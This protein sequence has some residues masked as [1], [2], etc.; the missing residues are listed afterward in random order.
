MTYG[1]FYDYN[2]TAK[3]LFFRKTRLNS[4]INSASFFGEMDANRIW[5]SG[6]GMYIKRKNEFSYYVLLFC[7][8]LF[9]FGFMFLNELDIYQIIVSYFQNSNE[10]LFNSD[11]GIFF[12]DSS[13]ITFIKY[14]SIELH[15]ALKYSSFEAGLTRALSLFQIVVPL[16]A[17]FAGLIMYHNQTSCNVLKS[18][19]VKKY[20]NF[21]RN[22]QLRIA[23]SVAGSI[24]SAYVLYYLLILFIGGGRF[25]AYTIHTD[26]FLDVLGNKFYYQHLKFYYFLLG[27][28][29]YLLI[30][31]VLAYLS[32]SIALFSTKKSTVVF[33]LLIYYFGLSVLMFP[34]VSVGTI[35]KFPIAMLFAPSTI[36][37]ISDYNTSPTILLFITNSMPLILG[38][39]LFNHKTR[40][41]HLEIS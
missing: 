29:K 30:P 25:D 2:E 8:S 19:R 37:S 6:W 39:V 15:N 5:I 32:T 24:F 34:L 17:S 9:L 4:V 38:Y 40:G 35:G 12:S 22:E 31:F 23:I 18:Y 21:I 28:V 16:L 26:L 10:S 1:S 11:V 14:T 3:L 36:F 13:E 33:G 41:K 7:V 20:R 27:I